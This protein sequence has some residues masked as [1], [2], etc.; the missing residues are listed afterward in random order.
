MLSTRVHI[1][2]GNAQFLYVGAHVQENIPTLHFN[3]LLPLKSM[4]LLFDYFRVGEVLW[5]TRESWDRSGWG[6]MG[7]GDSWLSFSF[8]RFGRCPI[9]LT[10]V[11]LSIN[12][13]PRSEG[14]N[15]GKRQVV[16]DVDIGPNPR[17]A[18]SVPKPLKWLHPTMGKCDAVNAIHQ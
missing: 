15:E 14:E 18:Q 13:V 8:H 7:W 5:K 3:L 11:V 10:S 9:S 2:E 12:E 6:R 1:W 17:S 16:V 4:N